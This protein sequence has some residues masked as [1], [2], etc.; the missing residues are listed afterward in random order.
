MPPK[1]LRQ[2]EEQKPPEEQREVS[3]SEMAQKLDEQTKTELEKK[4]CPTCGAKADLSVN[5]CPECSQNF[6][7]LP[8]GKYQTN[9][10]AQLDEAEINQKAAELGKEM[11]NQEDREKQ[12]ALERSRRE[13][14]ELKE[15]RDSYP[16]PV[17][18]PP[19]GAPIPAKQDASEKIDPKDVE[20]NEKEPQK[21]PATAANFIKLSPEGDVN[22][23]DPKAAGGKVET[24]DDLFE[25]ENYESF[26]GKLKGK[27]SISAELKTV[28]AYGTTLSGVKV[29]GEE[30]T[31]SG[32][33]VKLGKQLIEDV[34]L[35]SDVLE[36]YTQWA[37][38][39]KKAVEPAKT[40]LPAKGEQITLTAKSGLSKYAAT[41]A[42]VGS[43]KEGAD[44]YLISQPGMKE[45][46][47]PKVASNGVIVYVNGKNEAQTLANHEELDL[48]LES[49]KTNL[50]KY[51]AATG[52][53]T[54]KKEAP[55]DN[56]E[57]KIAE[58]PATQ[59]EA[60]KIEEYKYV[61]GLFTPG[62]STDKCRLITKDKECSYVELKRTKEGEGMFSV[63]SAGKVY[64]FN[65]RY[66]LSK[67]NLTPKQ[68]APEAV[69]AIAKERFKL[70]D[71][72]YDSGK[73]A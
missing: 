44:I 29:D 70:K 50:P 54:D 26:V 52:A 59:P 42:N 17:S 27:E 39:K 14:A 37:A 38:T 58:I 36:I 45:L 1:K 46:L 35:K 9:R 25:K 66:E 48:L 47:A 2:P 62:W 13:E 11:I 28:S 72:F 20:R 3:I 55:K 51:E 60:P 15:I 68:V 21:Q 32:D 24:I 64:S 69:I 19:V 71:V 12:A 33:N 10:P 6:S 7:E 4:E 34:K 30:Y 67:E 16:Q 57:G 22:M 40:N 5:T 73:S 8:S 63:K 23:A 65:L 61:S 56:L 18:T 53:K 43:E 31:I 41:F 49:Y